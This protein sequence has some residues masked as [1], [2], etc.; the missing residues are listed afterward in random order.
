MHIGHSR[1]A[2]IIASLVM[3]KVSSAVFG[4]LFGAHVLGR[5]EHLDNSGML[6]PRVVADDGFAQNDVFL[7]HQILMLLPGRLTKPRSLIMSPRTLSR[8]WAT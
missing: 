2:A 1:P 6:I 3:R 5:S 8:Q 4:K 7:S